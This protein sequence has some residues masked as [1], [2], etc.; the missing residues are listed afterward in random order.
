M[1]RFFF[2]L[3]LLAAFPIL[4]LGEGE[5]KFVGIQNEGSF[6]SLEIYS[7]SGG[8]SYGLVSLMNDI[9]I[10]DPTL[11]SSRFPLGSEYGEC[12]PFSGVFDGGG[13]T[14]NDFTFSRESGAALFCG[15]KDAVVKNLVIDSSCRFEGINSSAISLKAYGSVTFINVTNRAQVQGRKSAGAFIAN[16]DDINGSLIKFNKCTNEANVTFYGECENEF[17]AGGFI[18][19]ISGT[20]NVSVFFTKSKSNEAIVGS[21]HH[22]VGGFVGR[23]SDNTKIDLV[24]RECTAEYPYSTVYGAYND[25]YHGGFIGQLQKNKNVTL[26]IEDAFS[27]GNAIV[28]NR[29][30][31]GG[32]AG[33]IEDNV[34]LTIGVNRLEITTKVDASNGDNYKHVGGFTG[35]LR[36]NNHSTLQISGYVIHN[37][38]STVTRSY[39]GGF[40]GFA[41]YNEDMLFVLENFTTN[42]IIEFNNAENTYYH[43]GVFGCVES[44]KYTNITIINGAS[45]S[46]MT[47]SVSCQTGGFIGSVIGNCDTD[48]HFNNCTHTGT[49]TANSQSSLVGGFIGE[50]SNSNTEKTLLSFTNCV[51]DCDITASE[52]ACGFFCVGNTR[53]ENSVESS[54]DNCINKGKV[55]G[56]EEYGVANIVTNASNV[57]NMGTVGSNGQSQKACLWTTVKSASSSF[58]FV[59][60]CSDKLSSTEPFYNNSGPFC[61]NNDEPCKLLSSV[62][63]NVSRSKQFGMVWTE[64]L[65]LVNAIRVV[66]GKPESCEVK[67]FAG[68]SLEEVAKQRGFSLTDYIVVKRSTEFALSGTEIFT[69]DTELSLCH[70]IVF[71]G[72]I[73]RRVRV[74]EHGTLLGDVDIAK[75]LVPPRFHVTEAGNECN[76]NTRV[77]A[78][79]TMDVV[80]WFLLTVSGLV[81]YKEFVPPRTALGTVEVLKPFF[82]ATHAVVD[83][84]TNK[85]I[86]D[87]TTEVVGNMSVAVKK[88]S[89]LELELELEQDGSDTGSDMRDRLEEA[90]RDIVDGAIG[91]I[92]II[93]N[94]DTIIVRITV[95]DESDAEEIK[96]TFISCTTNSNNNN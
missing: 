54:V 55:V 50:V 32:F 22:S 72:D 4:S 47:S 23:V 3:L 64:D 8:F 39:C 28:N 56:K 26:L 57:I 95:A 83:A 58:S 63:N 1:V 82:N 53:N 2:G 18:G 74:V 30:Y 38:F 81:S 77:V 21:K 93:D 13:H 37:G 80:E 88:L 62:L 36:N 9:S 35:A 78:N 29:C 12:I 86:L 89:S 85:D 91:D 52:K 17:A 49:I 34:N 14:I 66:F 24:F 90:I 76:E 48:I 40:A 27:K 51:N 45:E 16:A 73:E 33:I 42:N 61:I 67:T 92:D 60:G 70:E 68:D 6:W 79:M 69:E 15:L 5:P 44:N 31:I 94:G 43:G 59:S 25:I 41:C 7:T 11:I 84:R 87:R 46:T 20:T 10:S 96:N 19:T 75:D 65:T 71:Q